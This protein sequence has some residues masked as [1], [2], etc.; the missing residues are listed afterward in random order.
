MKCVPT[1]RLDASYALKSEFRF[2]CNELKNIQGVTVPKCYGLFETETG[3]TLYLILQYCGKPLEK[4]F[5][6]IEMDQK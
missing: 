3:R 5:D 2:Y 6:E 1:Y 4:W